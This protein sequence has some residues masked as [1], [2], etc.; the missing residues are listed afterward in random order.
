MPRYFFNMSGGPYP[1]P[2]EGIDLTGPDQAR[3]AAVTFAA[4]MLKEIDGRFW[5]ASEWRLHVTDEQGGT[6][7]RPSLKGT[8]A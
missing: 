5:D 7:C 8:L 2:D 4:E 6:V 1:E 3:S